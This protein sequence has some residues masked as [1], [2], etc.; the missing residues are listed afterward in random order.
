MSLAEDPP[1]ALTWEEVEEL[2][3][4]KVDELN[5]LCEEEKVPDGNS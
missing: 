3:I 2:G 1:I 4:D 5:D